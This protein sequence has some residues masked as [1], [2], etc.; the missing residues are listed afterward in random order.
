MKQFAADVSA[1]AVFD[2][3]VGQRLL[4]GLA[5]MDMEGQVTVRA[6]KR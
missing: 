5:D 3:P 6:G 4:D 2:G 1:A